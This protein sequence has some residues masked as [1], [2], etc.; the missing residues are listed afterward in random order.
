MAFQYGWKRLLANFEGLGIINNYSEEKYDVK[1]FPSWPFDVTGK[2]EWLS[3]DRS[4][5]FHDRTPN[6]RWVIASSRKLW[7][8]YIWKK[9]Y[10]HVANAC[11]YHRRRRRCRRRFRH[12]RHGETR[13]IG[14]CRARGARV[15]VHAEVKDIYISGW[16]NDAWTKEKGLTVIYKK[17][18]LFC[19]ENVATDGEWR[20]KNFYVRDNQHAHGFK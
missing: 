11:H 10:R 17:R 9:C 8:K 13:K 14:T 15:F 5:P 7:C 12:R 18:Y 20:R 2:S 4:V 6:L 3:E 1:F 19:S 16:I